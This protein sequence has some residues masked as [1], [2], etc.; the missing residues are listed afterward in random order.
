M[1]SSYLFSFIINVLDEGEWSGESKLQVAKETANL[2][3][4]EE[5][6]CNL[7]LYLMSNG[8]DPNVHCS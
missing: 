2:G 5:V 6:I 8:F 7:S 1:V 4:L 3:I